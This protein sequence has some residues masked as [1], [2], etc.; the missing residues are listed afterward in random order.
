MGETIRATLARMGVRWLAPGAIQ[1]AEEE[2][3]F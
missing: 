1:T 3:A 2:T